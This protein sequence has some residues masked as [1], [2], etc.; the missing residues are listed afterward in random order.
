MKKVLV[1][2]GSG[3]IGEHLV[4]KLIGKGMKVVIPARRRIP[5]FDEFE[6]TGAEIY[7]G[8]LSDRN[9][10]EK[11]ISDVECVIHLAGATKSFNEKQMYEV[12]TGYTENLLNACDGKGVHFIYISSQA[13]AGPASSPSSGVTENE[14]PRPLTWY[15]KSKL[16]AEEKVREWGKKNF[17]S[18]T[19]IRPC[20]VY[21][22]GEKDI[23]N[24]FKLVSRNISI[25]AGKQG[26]ML[27][28]IYVE[29]LVDAIV[30]LSFE[31]NPNGKTY[32]ASGD[33]DSTWE[34]FSA[35]LSKI[36]N[37]PRQ[38]KVNVPNTVVSAVVLISE[39]VAFFRKKPALLGRQKMIEIKQDY[40]LCD[41]RS[42]KS[43]GWKPQYSL[44]DGLKKTVQWYV[45]NGWLK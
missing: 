32:F 16:K 26:K 40:W 34:H 14:I 37:K 7:L 39:C 12:N 15:G 20:S 30:H 1:T 27:S 22:P 29:D 11:I 4:G 10:L 9:F 44:S 38:I 45:Y 25:T 23:F 5:E 33:E 19:I 28:L 2:G 3:F 35:V 41:N 8:E 43:T 31:I 18:Y 6:K 13:A 21:G 42:L 36:M 17:N 24:Y